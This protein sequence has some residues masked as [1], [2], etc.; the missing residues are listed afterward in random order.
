MRS[1]LNVEILGRAGSDASL[2][3]GW[4]AVATARI[5]IAVDEP[6]RAG[7]GSNATRTIWHRVVF[8]GD[9]AQRAHE[10]IYKGREV[11]VTATLRYRDFIDQEGR[12]RREACLVGNAFDAFGPPR[13][14][15]PP[16]PTYHPVCD[17]NLVWGQEP[18]SDIRR[19]ARTGVVV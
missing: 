13:Q 19:E 7:D 16:A 17:P 2:H 18:V 6:F 9:L 12:A 5:S 4:K 8:F 10:L 15:D 11:L 1:R 14:A 3:F